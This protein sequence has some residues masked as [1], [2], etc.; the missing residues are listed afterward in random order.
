MFQP[1]PI[2]QSPF[3]QFGQAAAGFSQSAGQWA[4]LIMQMMQQRQQQSHERSAAALQQMKLRLEQVGAG[5]DPK[6]VR[7]IYSDTEKELAASGDPGW[8]GFQFS[9]APGAPTTTPPLPT[10]GTPPVQAGP[11]GPFTNIPTPSTQAAQPSAG[12]FAAT[13]PP[14]VLP[15]ATGAPTTTGA[16]GD[17]IVP[18]T[19]FG[20]TRLRDYYS[21]NPKVL[22]EIANNPMLGPRFLD[23][24]VD[25]ASKNKVF[26]AMQTREAMTTMNSGQYPTTLRDYAQRSGFKLRQGVNPNVLDRQMPFDKNTLYPDYSAADKQLANY[27]YHPQDL[28]ALQTQF[29]DRL[30]MGISSLRDLRNEIN[31]SGV[32]TPNH[33]RDLVN[34]YNNTI[35]QV[36]QNLAETGQTLRQAGGEPNAAALDQFTPISEQE[37][38]DINSA[39][40]SKENYEKFR[41]DVAWDHLLL[42]RDSNQ[43]LHAR[44]GLAVEAANRAAQNFDERMSAGDR[45]TLKY[46]NDPSIQALPDGNPTKETLRAR[47][48][49]IISR[50][51]GPI[52]AL[53]DPPNKQARA[54]E[55][56]RFNEA[57]T[58][59]AKV[60]GDQAIIAD[61]K[62]TPA[63]K[64]KAQAA[65]DADKAHLQELYK[66]WDTEH[67]GLRAPGQTILAPK[68][69]QQKATWTDMLKDLFHIN[70][71]KGPKPEPTTPPAPGTKT[72]PSTP[73]SSG[74]APGVT[75]TG[76]GGTISFSLAKRKYPNV[77]DAVL[78]QQ[79]KR[80]YPDATIGP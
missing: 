26:E 22:D 47:A 50:I 64:Q 46:W 16:A 43:L 74:P 79:L 31:K 14:S 72:A 11:T 37:L 32:N 10:P 63:Q 45:F 65:L 80:Q 44:Y 33:T 55:V 41:A 52:D 18:P 67:P 77:P 58:Y 4:P 48:T 71:G 60:A 24:T 68:D 30:K 56:K 12:P 57:K 21:N 51:A 69:P 15:A 70:R 13:T 27:I 76:K 59:E 62:A 28:P 73:P 17:I 36:R 19:Q 75:H 7:G 40:R 25:E 42:A 5:A 29:N 2:P 49:G 66:E 35:T 8:T 34:R 1:S 23:A 61:D 78:R 54:R 53:P 39:G 20:Q 6:V 9:R 3:E 38:V